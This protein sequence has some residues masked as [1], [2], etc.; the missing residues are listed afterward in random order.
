MPDL[1]HDHLALFEREFGQIPYGR[2]FHPLLAFV[3]RSFKPMMAACKGFAS[4]PPPQGSTVIQGAIPETAHSIMVQ[5]LRQLR[6]SHQ[7]YERFLHHVF[8]F[9]VAETQRAAV[10]D[11]LGG[12][13][14]VK[15]LASCRMSFVCHGFH[16]DRHRRAGIC[17]KKLVPGKFS[18]TQVVNY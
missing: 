9:R 15:P 14:F 6:Q 3:G 18:P 17:I 12:L 16:W 5:L 11:K 13:G 1:Q 10:E 7:C 2:I 4:E 8:G